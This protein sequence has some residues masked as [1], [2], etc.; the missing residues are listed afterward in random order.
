MKIKRRLQ[1]NKNTIL[2]VIPQFFCEYL[3]LGKG[4]K[5]V[6]SLENGKIQLE[7]DE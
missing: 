5:V 2:T 6:F 4:D 1:K 3:K 7:K